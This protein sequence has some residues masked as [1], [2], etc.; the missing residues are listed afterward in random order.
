MGG[1]NSNPREAKSIVP[2]RGY[3]TISAG[4]S[5]RKHHDTALIGSHHRATRRR[6]ER[7]LDYC[8]NLV[9]RHGSRLPRP[10]QRSASGR[11]RRTMPQGSGQLLADVQAPPACLAVCRR[12]LPQV[13]RSTANYRIVAGGSSQETCGQT[14]RRQHTAGCRPCRRCCARF[15]GSACVAALE[16]EDS[17]QRPSLRAYPNNSIYYRYETPTTSARSRERTPNNPTTTGFRVSDALWAVLEPLIPV[18]LNTHRFGGGRPRVPTD[19]APTLSSTSCAPAVSG[20]PS[21]TLTCVQI[22][23][24]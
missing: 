17:P 22:D 11:S 23:C 1:S 20:K 21:S 8:S 4:Q 9:N 6:I 18:R 16:L 13:A 24:S 14:E 7:T 2:C 3:P 12:A 10:D 19:A 5:P 15:P